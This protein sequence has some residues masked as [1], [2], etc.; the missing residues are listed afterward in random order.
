MEL[1]IHTTSTGLST[2]VDVLPIAVILFGFQALVIR[3]R[4]PNLKRVL[5]EFVMS[6][7]A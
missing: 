7:S 4:P 6:W 3:R 1:L 5:S 2:V